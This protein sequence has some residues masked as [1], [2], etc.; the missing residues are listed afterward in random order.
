[1]A[2]EQPMPLD[3]MVIIRP[4]AGLKIRMEHGKSYLPD[5][6]QLLYPTSYWLRRY[7]D[8]DVTFTLPDS[9]DAVAEETQAKEE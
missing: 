8:G 6:G 2:T 7:A 1:M 4:A 3:R 9:E 5:N